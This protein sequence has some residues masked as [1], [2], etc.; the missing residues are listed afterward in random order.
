[1]RGGSSQ[2][3]QFWGL[4]PVWKDCLFFLLPCKYD[5]THRIRSITEHF[6]GAAVD[7]SHCILNLHKLHGKAWPQRTEHAVMDVRRVFEVSTLIAQPRF[8][9][10]LGWVG[11]QS[12]PSVLGLCAC[13]QGSVPCA[14]FLVI[15]Q[16][17][18]PNQSSIQSVIN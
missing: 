9:A 7:H 1:M 3:H 12:T 14:E 18:R 8:V 2:S 17:I 5:I 6:G 11:N 15:K 16:L 4:P 10:V 13:N